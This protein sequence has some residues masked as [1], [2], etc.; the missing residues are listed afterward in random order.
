LLEFVAAF[1]LAAAMPICMRIGGFF[2]RRSSLTASFI[3]A[4]PTDF[5]TGCNNPAFYRVKVL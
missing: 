5:S 1:L 4:A 2:Y 3:L